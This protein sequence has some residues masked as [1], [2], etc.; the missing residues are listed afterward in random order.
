MAVISDE[1]ALET[2]AREVLSANPK[3]VASYRAGKTAV[4]GF[5]VGQIMKQ[6]K[7]SAN[8]ATV[9]AVLARLLG[10]PNAAS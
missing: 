9:N 5:F 3:Q 7:G 1:S 8:P 2:I 6:T 4:L 10:S